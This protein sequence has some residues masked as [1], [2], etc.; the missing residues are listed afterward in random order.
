LKRRTLSLVLRVQ[1]R[2]LGQSPKPFEPLQ[3]WGICRQGQQRHAPCVRD[4]LH[5]GASL[6]AR[7]VQAEGEG[8]TRVGPP[9]AVS[10]LTDGL[11]CHRRERLDRAP[12]LGHRVHSRQPIHPLAA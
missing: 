11:G 12:L 3:V 5:Q 1:T 7:L 6:I 4:G 2:L 9:Q 8:A 10:S